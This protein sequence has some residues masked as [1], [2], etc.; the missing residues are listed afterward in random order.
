MVW[1]FVQHDVNLPIKLLFLAFKNLPK[2][3]VKCELCGGGIQLCCV[4]WLSAQSHSI[5]GF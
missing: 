1:S 5:R 3:D 4:V 2:R